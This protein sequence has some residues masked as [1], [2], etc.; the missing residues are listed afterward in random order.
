M[1]I[2]AEIIAIGTEILL[3]EITDTNSV[4]IARQL[5]DI[6]VNLYFMTSVGDN[7]GRIADSIRVAMERA[8][9]VI[10]CGGLGPTIDDMTRQAVAD[11]TECEL[12]FHQRL[13]DQIAARFSSF[14]V[15]MSENNKR[16]AYLP[17]D[18][19]VIENPVGTA[20]SFI[21]E[22]QG[23]LVISLP[24]VPREMKYLMNESVIPYLRQRYQLGIIKARILKTAGIGESMLDEAI[25]TELLEASNPTVGLAAHNGQVDVRI[26]AK[27]DS[28]EAAQVMIAET[29]QVLMGRI[30][31]YVY[32]YD[33]DVLEKVLVQALKEQGKMLAVIEAGIRGAITG[34]IQPVDGSILK[35]THVY[36]HP[37]NVREWLQVSTDLSMREL[38]IAAAQRLRQDSQT[39]VSIAVVSLPEVEEGADISEGTAVTVSVGELSRT[40]VY[41]FG[42]Q[43][44]L[45]RRWVSM[46]AMAA[47]WAMLKG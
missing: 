1:N 33:D 30:G 21:V 37:E 35:M 10:T 28:L 27:A 8:D 19:I 2:N 7:R 5:R 43:S 9:I 12:V 32:G 34:A 6:G 36:D 42:G 31:E 13:L 39:E 3:G 44:D 45:A 20:P 29:E 14:K 46:W 38:S 40:R 24:G 11:A 4:F 16:Q 47:V 25:G 18:A 23:K 26:T 22:H 17:A 41:G 15:Q